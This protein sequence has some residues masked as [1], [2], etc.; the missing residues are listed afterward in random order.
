MLTQTETQTK[1]KPNDNQIT[2]FRNLI[3]AVYLRRR[4][5][6]ECI[7]LCVLIDECGVDY[8]SYSPIFTHVYL[9]KRRLGGVVCLIQYVR[10]SQTLRSMTALFYRYLQSGVCW[11]LLC[12]AK[13][14][15]F[16]SML[17]HNS[18]TPAQMWSRYVSILLECRVPFVGL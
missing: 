7:Y 11:T 2:P 13:G 10:I 17:L 3:Q 18:V 8:K 1:H 12:F 6:K 14:C 16:L 5:H 4:L 9:S 15:E